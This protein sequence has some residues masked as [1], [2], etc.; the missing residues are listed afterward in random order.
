MQRMLQIYPP[1]K[2]DVFLGRML[3][4]SAAELV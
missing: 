1:P 3:Q 2:H 4:N